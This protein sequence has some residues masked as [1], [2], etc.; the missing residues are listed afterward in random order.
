METRVDV[1]QDQAAVL[2]E[3]AADFLKGT[4]AHIH[5]PEHYLPVE[6]DTVLADEIP[7]ARNN[8]AL[9]TLRIAFDD[10]GPCYSVLSGPTIKGAGL[11]LA[12][13]YRGSV[14]SKRVEI[15][16]IVGQERR[17]LLVFVEVKSSM[18]IRVGESDLVEANSGEL[19]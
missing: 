5:A 13:T 1:F 18:A 8:T 15:P 7:P 11:N 6:R 16:R 12:R 17:G 9:R 14:L 10:A 3:E 2:L 19:A 4:L